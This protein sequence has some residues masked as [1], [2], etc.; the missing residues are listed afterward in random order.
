MIE[1][2][3]ERIT[4]GKWKENCYV[5]SNVNNDALIIDPGSDEIRIIN[6]IKDNNLNADAIIN[7][8]AHYDHVGAISKLKD[9]FLIVIF[10]F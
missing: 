6:F 4:N 2:N 1:L 9:E 7:T 5:V 10:A 3:I 8:H